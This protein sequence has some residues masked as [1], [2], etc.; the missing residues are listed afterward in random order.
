MGLEYTFLIKSETL[1]IVHEKMFNIISHQGNTNQNHNEMPLHTW[2][3]G[4]NQ[5]D[6]HK[7]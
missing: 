1:Q 7:H 4:Y 2:W 5:K 3:I 6:D